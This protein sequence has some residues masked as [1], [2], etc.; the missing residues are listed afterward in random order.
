MTQFDDDTQLDLSINKQKLDI[1]EQLAF[2]E[3]KKQKY[4]SMMD[5]LLP[6]QREKMYDFIES[7][8]REDQH[9]V[10]T[11][12]DIYD[13]QNKGVSPQER[14]KVHLKLKMDEKRSIQNFHHAFSWIRQEVSQKSTPCQIKPWSLMMIH[15]KLAEGFDDLNPGT[16]RTQDHL[17]PIVADMVAPEVKIHGAIA[18][19]VEKIIKYANLRVSPASERAF[20]SIYNLVLL[21]PFLDRNKRSSLLFGNLVLMNEGYPPLFLDASNKDECVYV[22]KDYR[23]TESPKKYYAFMFKEYHKSIESVFGRLSELYTE[24]IKIKNQIQSKQ[25]A[26]RY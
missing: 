6:E 12:M 5:A 8:M 15:S 22:M 14:K 24:S 13:Q 1:A 7:K 26:N 19:Q 25:L 17:R 2:L 9:F 10:K 4:Q 23:D 11:M 21:Q 18:T 3:E 20:E 16:Y